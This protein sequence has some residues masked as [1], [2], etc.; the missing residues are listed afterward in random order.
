MKFA[1]KVIAIQESKKDLINL[2]DDGMGGWEPARPLTD[3]R[4]S[5]LTGEPQF[6]PREAALLDVLKRDPKSR[7]VPTALRATFDVGTA[8][9]D[10]ITN[11][12]LANHAVGYW[13]CVVCKV[14]S[15][16]SKRPTQCKYCGGTEFQYTESRFVGE[17]K[18][19]GSIDLLV[20][21]GT[22]KHTLVELKIM[23]PDQFAELK[24]PLAEHRVRT[25]LYMHIVRT[26]DSPLKDRINTSRA[27][28][29]YVSRGHGKKHETK[30]TVL[31]FKEFDVD[32]TPQ[33]IQPY[34]KKAESIF[35]FREEKLMPTGIC[36]TSFVQRVK[37]CACPK[38]CFSGSYPAQQ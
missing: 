1:Q 23:A 36:A 21:F 32:Y 2:L 10:L 12:W 22:G 7:Y 6:C 16:F 3:I 17:F 26:S 15:D 28:I 5:M 38:E 14:V 19:G 8:V 9:Q 35:K 37:H 24:A 20:D 31:P 25:V 29:L 18:I 33:A 34:L 27:K 4:A 13:R 30:N 11:K